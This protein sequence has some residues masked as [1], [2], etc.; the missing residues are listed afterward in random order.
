MKKSLLLIGGG[1][2]CKSCIDVI[3]E[4]GK[5]TIE[6]IIDSIDKVGTRVLNYTVIGDDDSIEQYIARG[7]Y[8]L[9][10]IGQVRSAEKRKK[11]YNGI[12]N[13]NGNLA[14]IISPLAKVSRYAH[15]GEGSIVMHGVYINADANVGNNVILNTGCLIEHDAVIKDHVHVSTHAVINGAAF[16]GEGSF[17][18][19]K[20]VLV[21]GAQL[22][23]EII[24]GAGSVVVKDIRTPGVYV[25]NPTKQLMK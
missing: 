9:I 18:G 7:F 11:L 3:E 23:S 10:T 19:S 1:G 6:G 4:E 15:V 5:Y 24:L 22:N 13:R 12:K 21:Q 20:S 16:I 25:G 2:H 17:I 8:F 14:T